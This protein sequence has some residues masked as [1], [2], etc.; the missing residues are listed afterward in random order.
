MKCP[1]CLEEIID[2]ARVCRFCGK[3]QPVVIAEKNKRRTGWVLAIVLVPIGL[4]AL[5]A[6]IGSQIPEKSPGDRA[7]EACDRQY[8]AGAEESTQCAIA[9]MAEDLRKQ[10]ED[11]LKQAAR[12][13]GVQ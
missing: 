9:L 7:K 10:D 11:K 3:D 6:A 12:D 13:A 1:Y 4:L 5:L 8:G 2:G